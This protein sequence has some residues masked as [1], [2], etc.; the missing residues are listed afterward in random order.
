MEFHL[1]ECICCKSWRVEKNSMRS[2]IIPTRYQTV[3][4]FQVLDRHGKKKNLPHTWVHT[5]TGIAQMYLVWMRK[6]RENKSLLGSLGNHSPH[7]QPRSGLKSSMASCRGKVS[8][9]VCS[10]RTQ[11]PHR[12]TRWAFWHIKPNTH[13]RRGSEQVSKSDKPVSAEA[14]SLNKIK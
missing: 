4:R 6:K 9:N 12:R 13:T 3:L 1:T 14:D 2:S 10:A 5:L 11:S 7:L 8:R